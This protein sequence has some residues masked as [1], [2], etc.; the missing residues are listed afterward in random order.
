MTQE[1]LEAN[2]G[3]DAK[4]GSLP[5]KR[6][7]ITPQ[8][9]RDQQKLARPGTLIHWAAK[10]CVRGRAKIDERIA[11]ATARSTLTTQPRLESIAL[12][13]SGDGHGV[14]RLLAFASHIE[15]VNCLA[16]RKRYFAR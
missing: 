10:P 13:L 4:R 1:Q 11:D 15:N 16:C 7:R 8:N 6:P 9:I 14:V 2:W 3:W 5:F 12:G